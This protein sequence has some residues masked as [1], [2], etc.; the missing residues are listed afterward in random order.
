MCGI[1]GELSFTT[2]AKVDQ[3]A[4]MLDKLAPRGPDGQGLYSLGPCCL[5]HRRLKII[6]LSE[7]RKS[8][9]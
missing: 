4:A 7:D 9:V 6:D 2:S 1:A 8:V 5:G 3:V